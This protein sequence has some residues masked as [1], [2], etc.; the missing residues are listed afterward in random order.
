MALARAIAKRPQ[1]MV[2]DEPTGQLDAKTGHEMVKLIRDTGETY[3]TTI[4]MVTHDV[5]LKKYGDRVIHLSSG[6]IVDEERNHV[7]D[8]S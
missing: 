6:R 4:I 1:I 5:S 3:G 7:R 2:V 8:E